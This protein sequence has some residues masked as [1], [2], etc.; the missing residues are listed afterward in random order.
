MWSPEDSAIRMT[1]EIQ[2]ALETADVEQIKSI[3]ADAAVAQGLATRDY[4]SPDVLLPT[5]LAN[6][7]PKKFAKVLT[8]NGEKHVL[9]GESE[10]ALLAAEANLYRELFSQP[11]PAVTETPARDAATGRFVE[12]TDDNT[13]SDAAAK[14]ELELQFKRGEITAAQYI[15]RSGAVTEYLQNEGIDPAALREVSGKRLAD[16]WA[17]ATEEFLA[18][19]GASWPG[20]DANKNTLGRILTEQN[21]IDAEDK[22]AALAAAYRYAKDN[23]LLVETPESVLVQKIGSART[24]EELREALHGGRTS[25]LFGAH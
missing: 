1:P 25:G 8:I 24:A 12:R 15:Q 11:A 18:G 21:L 19:P 17:S 14:A 3:M 5:E 4:Y 16:S 6:A 20:G 10:A 2:K 22:V 7:A 23:N 9:E 13:A